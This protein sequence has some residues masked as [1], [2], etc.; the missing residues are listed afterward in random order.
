MKNYRKPAIAIAEIECHSP[1]MGESD[2][3]GL[4]EEIGGEDQGGKGYE[5]FEEDE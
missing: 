1:L 4:N 3:P 2:Y 5:W